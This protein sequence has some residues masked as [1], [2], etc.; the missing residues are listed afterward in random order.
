LLRYSSGALIFLTL[1]MPIVTYSTSKKN[2]P[3]A[4]QCLS[5]QYPYVIQMNPDSYINLIQD[6]K[7]YCGIAPDIC[8]IGFLENNSEFTIDDFYQELYSM[9]VANETNAKLIP[10]INL[11]DRKFHYFY[12]D[13]IV[14]I[15]ATTKN[16]L[17]G[18]A[19]EV[20]T[21]NQSI[22]VVETMLPVK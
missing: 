6:E 15:E 11:L 5:T 18:C 17:S 2:T 21:K 9:M 12:I 3:D 19:T 7:T 22:F 10:T 20:K 14:T 13:S 16:T 1:I 4:F 8:L